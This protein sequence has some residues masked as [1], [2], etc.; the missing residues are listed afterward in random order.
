VAQ[1]L[2]HPN[3]R[4]R[5]PL[6]PVSLKI[7]PPEARKFGFVPD[8]GLCKAGDLIL[9]QAIKPDWV[10]GQISDAQSLAGFASE[11]ARWT[12]AAMF[13]YHDFIVEAVPRGMM[14]VGGVT[15][16]SLYLDVPDSVLRIRRRPTLSE[17]ERYKIALCALRMLGSRYATTEAIRIGWRARMRSLV[18]RDWRPAYNRVIICSQVF[19]DSLLE[20]V[21]SPLD[22][23]PV[24]GTV[25]PAHLSAT[26]DLEDIS[27]PWLRLTA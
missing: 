16:R 27:V 23:C 7:V 4:G 17:E 8:F 12:H 5:G 14:T 15:T 11:H 25:L 3:D 22:G 18:N 9:S 6:S 20:I 21:R 24:G 19:N 2:I 26:S 1:I 10:D 13:L